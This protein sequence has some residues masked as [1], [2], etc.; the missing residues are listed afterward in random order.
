M[1]ESASRAWGPIDRRTD[2]Y[3]LG[4][5]LST[6]STGRPPFFGRRLPDV[7]AQVVSA[8]PVESSAIFRPDLP[9]P[10]SE[11]CRK[12]LCKASEGRF[13]GLSEVPRGLAAI[14]LSGR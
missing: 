9:E 2:V 12:C 5:V 11:L 10:L 13:Q 8:T 1:R 6:L 7:P 14:D 3:G 4:A